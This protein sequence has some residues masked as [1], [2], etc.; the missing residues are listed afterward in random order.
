[1]EDAC[2]ED[3]LTECWLAVGALCLAPPRIFRWRERRVSDDGGELRRLASY[4][5]LV[6]SSLVITLLSVV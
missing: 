6:T 2:V 1:M 3:C 5:Y 4:S